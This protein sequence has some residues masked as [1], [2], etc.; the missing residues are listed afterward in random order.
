MKRWLC[1]FLCLCLCASVGCTPKEKPIT[2]ADLLSKPFRC[3]M[4]ITVAETE[5]AG[6]FEKLSGKSMSYTLTK[7]SLL[8]GLV[9]SYR[10][11]EVGL[12]LGPLSLSLDTEGLPSSAVTNVL[13]DL[14]KEE[15]DNN[16]ISLTEELV[17]LRHT[18]ALDVTVVEFD[19]STLV[20]LRCYTERSGVFIVY[21]DYELL[22]QEQSG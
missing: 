5:F 4:T 3:Q 22:T 11:G 1:L 6:T 7:P 19:R 16:E 12:A 2:A 15:S 8:E 13:F 21:T 20:P 10:E 9:F 17:L 14:Y 18:G